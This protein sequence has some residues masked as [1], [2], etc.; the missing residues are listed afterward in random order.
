MLLTG[1]LYTMN[2]DFY[3]RYL[4]L[5]GIETVLPSN[6]EKL[7]INKIIFEELVLGRKTAQS[8]ERF[9]SI[10]NAHDV[11]AVLLG[12]TE[13]PQLVSQQDTDKILLDSLEIHS[14][15]AL[16]FALA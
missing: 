8:K 14:R 15:D 10:I 9:L 16:E 5:H 1:I 12:C 13:L 4:K 3:P 11:D 7:I 6:D 2:S